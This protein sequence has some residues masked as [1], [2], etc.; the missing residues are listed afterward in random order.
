LKT[1]I[2]LVV[3]V[4][5]AIGC[6]HDEKEEGP[7][8]SQ[9]APAPQPDGPVVYGE[10]FFPEDT[11]PNGTTWHWMGEEGV[12]SLPSAKHD[13]VLKI[14]G[15]VP[16]ERFR[17]PPAIALRLNGEQLDQF[18]ATSGRMEKVYTIRASRQ[19]GRDRSEL[20]IHT[21]QTFVPKEVDKASNDTRRLGFALLQLQWGPG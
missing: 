20:R 3:V 14:T 11:G 21:D 15:I 6:G 13:M 8:S 19:A 1:V 5:L 2:G 18:T 9:A 4:F 17:Q 16:V 12:I 10:G 7:P